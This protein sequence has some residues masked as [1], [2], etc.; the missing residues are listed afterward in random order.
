[1]ATI[2]RGHAIVKTGGLRFDGLLAW[3][4]WLFIHIFYLVGFR[5]RVSVF[6]ACSWNYLFSKRGSRLITD[7]EWRLPPAPK[8]EIHAVIDMSRSYAGNESDLPKPRAPEPQPV[9]I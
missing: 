5:N 8:S 6:F 7:R 4:A 1:M 3:L 9:N 2:G